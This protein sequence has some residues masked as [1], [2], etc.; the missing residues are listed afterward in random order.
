M[1]ADPSLR[2]TLD[3]AELAARRNRKTARRNRA[4]WVKRG[5]VAAAGVAL[6]LV[7][8]RSWAPAPVEVELGAAR[9]TTLAVWVEE[10]GR[11]RV[12]ERFVVA[13]PLAGQLRRVALEPGDAVREGETVATIDPPALDARGRAE[14]EARLAASLARERQAASVALATRA[15]RE[16]ALRE[17]DRARRLPPIALPAADRERA[18]L[19]AEAAVEDA[20]AA[21]LG[22]RVAAAEVSAARAALAAAAGSSEPIAVAAP[23]GGVVLAVPRESAGPVAAGAPL[24]EIGDPSAVEV[25][26]DVLSADAVQVVAGAMVEID[27]WGGEGTLRGRVRR[28]ERGAFT[29]VSAL[30]VEEQRVNVIVALDDAPP[31]LGDGFRV[32]ARILVWEGRDVLA[33]PASALFR[34][35][36]GWATF[37]AEEGRARKR[38]VEVGRRGRLDAEIVSGLDPDACVVLYPGSRVADG[39]AIV[40]R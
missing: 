36:D 24:V 26:I 22:R 32:E 31:A 34:D 39:V 13:A 33:V 37:V 10:D 4:R 9:R 5:L 20:A 7:L 35:G 11:T 15:A 29:R 8:V 17:A 6:V 21:E 3:D 1:S 25:V 23:V 38:A 2:P 27:R 19:Q 12:R 16:L 30:G 28:V 14:T 40:E 18:E